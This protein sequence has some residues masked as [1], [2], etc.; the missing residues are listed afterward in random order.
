VV[1]LAGILIIALLLGAQWF[2]NRMR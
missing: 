1:F 2:A